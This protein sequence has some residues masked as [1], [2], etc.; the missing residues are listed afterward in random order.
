MNQQE[1][2]KRSLEWHKVVLGSIAEN[3]CLLDRALLNV[4]HWKSMGHRP[5]RLYLDEWERAI[6]S[7]VEQVKALALREDEYANTLRQCSP[8][9]TLLPQAQ[10]WSFIKSYKGA[11]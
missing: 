2:D 3:P 10:R 9:A 5:D 11:V 1:H 7:G 6:H 4:Q 8:I